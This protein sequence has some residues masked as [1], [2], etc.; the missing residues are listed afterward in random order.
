MKKNANKR[1]WVLPV[2]T[3]LGCSG[4]ATA[5]DAEVFCNDSLDSGPN[6]GIEVKCH[7][8]DIV[9]GAGVALV[10]EG[11]AVFYYFGLD[12]EEGTDF[13]CGGETGFAPWQTPKFEVRCTENAKGKDGEGDLAVEVEVNLAGCPL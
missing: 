12:T 4:Q 2:V 5:Q 9:G 7:R 10:D 11:V 8:E 6:C 3:A 1:R 13:I